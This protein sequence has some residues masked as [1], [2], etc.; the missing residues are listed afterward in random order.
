MAENA[1]EMRPVPQ[2]LNL[3][4]GVVS[5]FALMNTMSGTF[6]QVFFSENYGVGCV[7]AIVGNA[8]APL[9]LKLM[10]RLGGS[11][12]PKLSLLASTGAMLF[13]LGMALFIDSL[14]VMIWGFTTTT[15]SVTCCLQYI[16]DMFSMLK[17]SDGEKAQWTAQRT[18][19]PVVGALA[20]FLLGPCF[21]NNLWQSQAAGLFVMT[22]MLPLLLQLPNPA[23]TY[24]APS[25]W[26]FKDL[27]SPNMRLCFACLLLQVTRNICRETLWGPSITNRGL[28]PT[29]GFPLDIWCWAQLNFLAVFGG[30]VG[31]V[32]SQ[33]LQAQPTNRF[34]I[35]ML[36]FLCWPLFVMEIRCE[37]FKSLMM[38]TFCAA[39]LRHLSTPLMWKLFDGI[40]SSEEIGLLVQ[41]S[42]YFEIVL[43]FVVPITSGILG[44][45]GF[46]NIFL[47]AICC[48]LLLMLATLPKRK[49]D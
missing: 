44:F 31:T 48:L 9:G 49:A 27:K 40:I 45:Y 16:Q 30:V 6:V 36:A 8:I 12:S 42:A 19:F 34:F 39:T 15:A 5:V 17:A 33:S 41:A 43:G 21:F 10:K 3:L 2:E 32:M 35:V 11:L 26:S 14:L 22:L 37:S 24:Q 20:G 28:D 25:A 7:V 38:S 23:S 4:L 18:I 47:T 29:F 1:V 13:G 46:G